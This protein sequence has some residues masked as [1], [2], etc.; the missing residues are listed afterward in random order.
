ML[1][2]IWI[3]IGIVMDYLAMRA[4]AKTLE[5]NVI[6]EYKQAPW[7]VHALILLIP[8]AALLTMF[9]D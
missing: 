5:T 4:T 6:M 9:D 2:L 7:W 8:P 3:T 1:I